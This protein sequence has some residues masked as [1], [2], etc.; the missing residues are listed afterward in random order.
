L[1]KSWL[2]NL[3]SKNREYGREVTIKACFE[4]SCQRFAYKCDVEVLFVYG[5][6]ARK[7]FSTTKTPQSAS[8]VVFSVQ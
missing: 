8:P 2:I 6:V 3:N 1:F 4:A 7:N 5:F